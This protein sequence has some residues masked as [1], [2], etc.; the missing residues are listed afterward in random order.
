MLKTVVLSCIITILGWKIYNKQK[1]LCCVVSPESFIRKYKESTYEELL[2]VR[3]KLNLMISNFEERKVS[4]HKK[5]VTSPS[6]EVA[7]QFNLKYLAKTCELI[8]EKINSETLPEDISNGEHYIFIIRSFLKSKSME[9]Y[10]D[11]FELAVSERKSGKHFSF[12]SHLKGLIYALLSN[13]TKWSRIKPHLKDIDKLFFYYETEKIKAMP[14][15]Y[16]YNGL[17]ALKCGNIRT[18]AQMESLHKNIS[19]FE[20]IETNFD[21]LDNF[22]DHAPA[23]DIVCMLSDVNS[24][25]KL[26]MIGEALAWEYLRYMGIDAAKPDTHLRRFLG[27]DRMG[28]GSKSPA[29]VD[30]VNTQIDILA[31]ATGLMKIEIDGLIW[32]FCAD[33]YGEICTASPKC[34]KCPIRQ[35]CKFK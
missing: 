22:L 13:Q 2:L 1:G 14:A 19:V 23:S 17:F 30:D 25:Y 9:F 11:V 20:K 15:K 29:T 6:S 27:A 5:A 12:S 35:Y 21:S 3:N 18:K 28:T 32:G 26:R 31:K 24:P 8:A 33:R 34:N 10:N 4:I 7:Y 16:F